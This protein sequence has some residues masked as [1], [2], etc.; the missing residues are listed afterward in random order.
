MDKIY[1]RNLQERKLDQRSHA[2][3]L[4]AHTDTH[5]HIHRGAEAHETSAAKQWSPLTLWHSVA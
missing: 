4:T 1:E 2:V 3:M 5:T